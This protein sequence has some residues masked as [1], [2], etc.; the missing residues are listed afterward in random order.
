MGGFIDMTGKKYGILTV[1]ER[2]GTA[3]DKQALWKCKCDCGNVC[4]IRGRDLRV[5][6]T[7]SCG[8]M[9]HEWTNNKKKI[10]GK[11]DTRLYNVWLSMK[12]RC[13]REN[14]RA[15]EH[16]GGRGIKVCLEWQ[17]FIPF[18]EW[19]YSNGYDEN[20]A[21]GQCT[22]DRIDVNG[23]YEPS[24]CRWVSVSVQANNRRNN[25]LIEFDGQIRTSKQWSDITGISRANIENRIDNLG[26][27]IEKALTKKPN[28]C[29]RIAK[30]KKE[31]WKRFYAKMYQRKLKGRITNDQFKEIIER[32]VENYVV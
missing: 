10:H 19:A 21:R 11:T 4:N 27:S 20:A 8:C 1:I 16:Y 15:Y 14:V 30:D 12:N 9:S 23:N 13:Y 25:R 31:D 5:G 6:H 17:E 32:E 18:M 22:L 7:R 28:T 26:W 3:N 2:I 24:N 29:R